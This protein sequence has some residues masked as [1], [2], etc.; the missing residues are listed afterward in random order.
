MVRVQC[1]CRAPLSA[2]TS[3]SSSAVHDLSG[4]APVVTEKLNPIVPKRDTH[5]RIPLRAATHPLL[6]IVLASPGATLKASRKE[7]RCW[8]VLRRFMSQNV[9]KPGSQRY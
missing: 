9:P 1:E 8:Q 6:H 2:G 4:M 5:N 7:R 3:W